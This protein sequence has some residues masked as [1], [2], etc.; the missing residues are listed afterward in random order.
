[1]SELHEG[2]GTTDCERLGSGNLKDLDKIV[3]RDIAEIKDYL[4]YIN[5]LVAHTTNWP[6]VVRKELG[7]VEKR[8][9]ALKE[10][11]RG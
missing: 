9:Q 4:D 8:I 1:M 3:E 5:G 11:C 7:Y 6:D 10:A 2:R